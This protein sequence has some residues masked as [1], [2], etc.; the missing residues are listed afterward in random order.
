MWPGSAALALT[1][2]ICGGVRSFT[3]AVRTGRMFRFGSL[4][5]I[6]VQLHTAHSFIC[7][8]AHVSAH[9]H[10][11]KD[12]ISYMIL[13][14][15]GILRDLKCL[16]LRVQQWID[17]VVLSSLTR[18]KW[19]T[20]LKIGQRSRIP[21]PTETWPPHGNAHHIVDHEAGWEALASMQNLNPKQD[22]NISKH[23]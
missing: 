7:I 17:I 15:W 4:V 16:G 9:S 18:R 22:Q 14:A 23:R 2:V 6:C 10:T 20:I 3:C 13:H 12:Q 19:Q 5:H 1:T 11:H 8:P 21:H